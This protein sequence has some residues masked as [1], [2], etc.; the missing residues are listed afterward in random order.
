MITRSASHALPWALIG[1]ACLG[2]FA[3][4]S[5]G[6]TRAPFLLEM[7]HDLDV[8][9]PLVANLVSMTA[10]AWGVTSAAAGYASDL[11]GRRALLIAALVALAFAMYGQANAGSFLWVA[12]WASAAGGCAGAFTGVVFTEVSSRV[13]DRQRGRALGWVMSGQ[14]LTLVV[15]VP[16]AAWIGS[17]IGWR[18]WNVCVG[19]LA[20]VA[21][22]ALLLTVRPDKRLAGTREQR[23]ALRSALSP[24]VLALLGT[25]IAER[26]CYGL[27]AVYFATFL[28]AIYRLSLAETAI[29]L[30]VFALGNVL[31]TIL[32]GQLADRLRD[33]L[34]TFAVTMALSG[35]AALGLFMWHPAPA[36]SV[37]L[38]FIYVMLNALGRPSYMASLAS[39]PDEVRGTVLGLNGT[40]ASVGWICAAGLGAVMISTIGFE[41][42]GPLGAVLGVLG[43]IGALL[44]RRMA[45]A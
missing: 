20:L 24:R 36:I 11:I 37:A 15:G 17:A 21:S 33:R 2:S 16:L 29:P 39:V 26:I 40:S 31:G 10:T 28:Q 23:P 22:F 4:T 9:M 14:S 34:R 25:G 45:S 5:S 8:S 7:A 44:C 1:A 42:F 43:T 38:G 13:E 32:G 41:G 3:A 30:A 35:F 18:G 27:A 6:T 19:G 12:V